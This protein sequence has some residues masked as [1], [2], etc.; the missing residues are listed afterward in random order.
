MA[1]HINFCIMPRSAD[2]D[3]EDDAELSQLEKKGLE[4]AAWFEKL[5]SA[6]ALLHA[7]RPSTIG[8][9]FSTSPLALLA[10]IGEKFLDWTDETPPL[11]TILESVS[12]YWLTD[13]FPTSIYPYRQLFTPGV[14]GAHEDPKW[15]VKKPMG[16][17]WFPKEIAPVPRQWV[18][19]TGDLVFWRE[20][21]KVCHMKFGSDRIQ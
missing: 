6:Y 13:T 11:D 15:F 19:T 16:M 2:I 12:L 10:W 14:V 17:S 5:G 21:D 1:L 20:H 7:T 18:E 9:A 8:L 3:T 4:R